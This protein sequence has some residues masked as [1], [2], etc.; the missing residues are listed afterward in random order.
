MEEKKKRVLA[1]HARAIV[2]LLSDGVRPSNKEAGYVLRRLMR[3]VIVYDTKVNVGSFS[4]LNTP[5]M[6]VEV[7]LDKVVETYRSFYPELNREL[8]SSEFREEQE[9]FRKTILQGLNALRE[10][11]VVDAVTAFNLYQS[12]GI[13]F[14]II[15]EYGEEKADM[16]TREDFDKEF[17]K[18]Q[19]ISRAG[20]ERKFGGHGLLLD[21]GELKAATIEE[22]RIVTRLH[23]ATHLLQAALR[24]V[25]G[26]TVHQAGSDITVERTRFDFTFDRKLTLEELQSVEQL[27]NEA[28]EKDLTM[29][30]KEMPFQ[31][32][33]ATGALY[34]FREKYPERVK[35]YTAWNP[36]MQEVFSRELCGG[37]HVS[38]TGEVGKVKIVKEEGV[39]A[40]VRRIRTVLE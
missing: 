36:H 7:L 18:H 37:P 8:I 16:L 9:K 34:S 11:K 17:V 10:L 29:E 25:L 27:V 4:G 24:K 22:L 21:T 38:H 35:V 23:T 31:E 28:V 12:F 40:G 33:I 13:P 3:R 1:D 15:K 30:Y 39:A 32:A 19:E 20:V 26:E 6:S 5:W 14:E 2:F